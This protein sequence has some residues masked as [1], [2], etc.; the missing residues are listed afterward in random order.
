V[1]FS[2]LFIHIDFFFLVSFHIEVVLFFRHAITVCTVIRLICVIGDKLF[3]CSTFASTYT[4]TTYIHTITK[5]GEK[6]RLCLLICLISE[7]SR[8]RTW[9]ELVLIG[10]L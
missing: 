1:H 4:D 5:R 3:V 8:P 7:S 6:A 10:V 2:F 9:P